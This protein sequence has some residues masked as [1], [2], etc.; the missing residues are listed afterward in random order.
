MFIS[1][2]KITNDLKEPEVEHRN[3]TTPTHIYLIETHRS[4][5]AINYGWLF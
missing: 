1:R 3:V 5:A 2:V 4:L